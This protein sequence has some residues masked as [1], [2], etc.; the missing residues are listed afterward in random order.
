VLGRLHRPG[1]LILAGLAVA[2][3]LAL[4]PATVCGGGR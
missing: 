4:T 3:L 2:A 1:M